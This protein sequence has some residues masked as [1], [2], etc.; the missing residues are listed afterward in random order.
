MR[1]EVIKR[2]RRKPR[3]G[4]I[5]GWKLRGWDYGFGRVIRTEIWRERFNEPGIHLVYLYKSFAPD[6]YRIP[7]LRR[8]LLLTPP[9]IVSTNLWEQGYFYTV[10]NQPL[11]SEDVLDQHCFRNQAS[12]RHPYCDE[13]GKPVRK[14]TGPCPLFALGGEYAIEADTC[15]ALG[16][17]PDPSPAESSLEKLEVFKARLREVATQAVKL[18]DPQIPAF[19]QALKE[20][21]DEIER[22]GRRHDELY[23]TIVREQMAEAILRAFVFDEP[24]YELPRQFGMESRRAD[25]AIRRALERYI[26]KARRLA[27]RHGLRDPAQRLRVFEDLEVTSR[28]GETYDEFFGA[29]L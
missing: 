21:L 20:L 15:R 4:D 13:T 1:L 16:I 29:S 7:V 23:D 24:D 2:S 5:F 18:P 12:L 14:P 25:A 9:R 10:C 17:E 27:R 8:D 11:S 6:L 3:E 19:K 26:D 28:G 22:I